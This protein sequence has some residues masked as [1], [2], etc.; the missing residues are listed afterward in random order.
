MQGKSRGRI[1]ALVLRV[2]RSRLRVPVPETD[3]YRS[4]DGFSQPPSPHQIGTN[5]LRFIPQH[6]LCMCRLLIHMTT[7]SVCMCA[8][9]RDAEHCSW[10]VALCHCL[11]LYPTFRINVVVSSFKG[12]NVQDE[13]V[14]LSFI[15]PGDEITMLIRNVGKQLRSDATSYAGRIDSLIFEIL[16]IL[17]SI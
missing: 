11:I 3:C 5:H 13:F 6:C 8:A 1:A 4:D 12:R 17:D 10:S 2:R 16:L 15:L 9:I 14:S 7:C